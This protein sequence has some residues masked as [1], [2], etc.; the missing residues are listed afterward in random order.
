MAVSGKDIFVAS[1]LSAIL[2]VVAASEKKQY[3][4]AWAQFESRS[5]SA[6]AGKR[7]KT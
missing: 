4:K 5:K 3:G 7:K 1:A 6:M 2:A